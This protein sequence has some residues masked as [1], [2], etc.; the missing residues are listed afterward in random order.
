VPPNR[1]LLV[2]L[3]RKKVVVD[4]NSSTRKRTAAGGYERGDAGVGARF[5]Q[6]SHRTPH[7]SSCACVERGDSIFKR[8]KVHAPAP[9]QLGHRKTDGIFFSL[10][11]LR[12]YVFVHPLQLSSQGVVLLHSFA[13][14]PTISFE[15]EFLPAL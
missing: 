15:D 8:G 12:W 4:R 2:V 5:L 11:H 9:A 7:P 10:V 1:C 13:Q 6:P 3:Q 14:Q